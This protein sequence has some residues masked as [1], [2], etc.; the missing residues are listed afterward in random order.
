MRYKN[1]NTPGLCISTGKHDP[2]QYRE[3]L[4]E[5]ISTLVRLVFST[6]RSDLDEEGC[7]A[8][9]LLMGL[10]QQLGTSDNETA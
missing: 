7:F 3:D 6:T 9:W 8:L 1:S 5:A 2:Q 4:H 10:Q